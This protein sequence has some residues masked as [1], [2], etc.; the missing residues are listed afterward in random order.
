MIVIAGHEV[1]TTKLLGIMVIIELVGGILFY[2]P[3]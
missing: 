2:W 1:T 3:K